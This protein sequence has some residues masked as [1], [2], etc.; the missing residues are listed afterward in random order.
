MGAEDVLQATELWGE[1]RPSLDSYGR[2]LDLKIQILAFMELRE[3]KLELGYGIF[4]VWRSGGGGMMEQTY[5]LLG[6]PCE[7]ALGWYDEFGLLRD[8]QNLIKRQSPC[9]I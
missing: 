7:E 4:M 1:T 5:V 9:R 3:A 2:L 6:S 8:W